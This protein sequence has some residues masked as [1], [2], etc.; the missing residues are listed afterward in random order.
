MAK[1]LDKKGETAASI[2]RDDVENKMLA[3]VRDDQRGRPRLPTPQNVMKLAAELGVDLAHVKATGENGTQITEEDVQ[4]A[5]EDPKNLLPSEAKLNDLT[6]RKA[7]ED[8]RARRE[9]SKPSNPNVSR[10]T[11]GNAETPKA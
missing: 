3:G 8:A 10:G 11:P 9:E 6:G 7:R 5:A 4:K 1:Y 2:T